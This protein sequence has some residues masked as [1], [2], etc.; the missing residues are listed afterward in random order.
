MCCHA[1]SLG[2]EPK[3]TFMTDQR[4]VVGRLRDYNCTGFTQLIVPQRKVDGS[5]T[6]SLFTSRD[7]ENKTEL[8]SPLACKLDRRGDEGGNATLHVRR[9]TTVEFAAF[10]IGRERINRPWLGT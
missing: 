8:V 5:G 3:C 1:L 4:P 10:H 7:D 2:R 9:T 6:A